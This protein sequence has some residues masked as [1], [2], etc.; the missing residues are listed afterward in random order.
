MRLPLILLS[1]AFFVTAMPAMSHEFWISPQTYTIASGGQLVADLRVGQNFAGSAYAFIP[2]R[3][4]RFDL[5]QDGKVVPVE[6]RVGDRPALAMEAISDG[7]VTVVHQTGNSLLTWDE[8]KKFEEFV[9]HKDFPWV[10]EENK[11]RGIP[12]AGFSERY[13]RYGKSLIAV[14][15]GKGSDSEVGLLTEIV[16]LANPYTDDIS[17]GFPVRVLYE[18]KPRADTQVEV[19]AKAADDTVEDLFYRTDDKGEVTI[20]VKPGVEYLVDAVVIRPLQQ[21]VRKD[22]V[23]ETLWASLTFKVPE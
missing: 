13:S 20:P 2:Q 15:E 12:E 18:G 4:A 22:P 21:R 5:V 1:A 3:F 6:G 14:G 8:A 7:L 9:K 16:A 17:D 23:W 10:L 11:T 19:F